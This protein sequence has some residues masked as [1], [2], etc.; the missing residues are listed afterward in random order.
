ME[1]P[2]HVRSVVDRNVVMRPI[3]VSS[4]LFLT[5]CFGRT[6]FLH[7][8]FS[9]ILNKHNANSKTPDLKVNILTIKIILRVCPSQ[10][11][12]VPA[13]ESIKFACSL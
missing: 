10:G 4:F 11:K 12:T 2:S 3:P 7:L 9:Y 6:I 5:A 13:T 1:P 8:Q